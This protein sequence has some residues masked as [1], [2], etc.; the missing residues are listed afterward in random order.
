MNTANAL[1]DFWNGNADDSLD[2]VPG[3]KFATLNKRATV[4]EYQQE[5]ENCEYV[6]ETVAVAEVVRMS[7]EDFDEFANSLLCDV[8]FLKGKG[9]HALACWS[10]VFKF[11]GNSRK[12]NKAAVRL[13]VL[14]VAPGRPSL[15]VDPQG[16][17]YARYVGL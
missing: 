6:R 14:V 10:K 5:V 9:G 3:V 16:Y 12:N 17:N 15:Y 1:Q 2:L 11:D 13:C 8:D 7:P 4:E